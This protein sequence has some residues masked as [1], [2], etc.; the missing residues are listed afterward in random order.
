M[1]SYKDGKKRKRIQRHCGDIRP[2]PRDHV[3][4]LRVGSKCLIHSNIVKRFVEGSVVSIYRDEEG[5]WLK[6]RY[7]DTNEH[8][9]C[10]IQRFSKELLVFQRH[11]LWTQLIDTPEPDG[12]WKLLETNNL[13]LPPKL[14]NV[15][16]LNDNTLLVAARSFEDDHDE[17][18]GDD[19]AESEKTGIYKYDIIRNQWELFIKYPNGFFSENHNICCDGKEEMVYL[20]N[21]AG[22]GGI[23][24]VHV[25]NKRF[26]YMGKYNLEDSS[27]YGSISCVVESQYHIFW[28]K[29][30]NHHLCWKGD[31][32]K[33][34]I[35][36]R[37]EHIKKGMVSF[38]L[39]YNDREKYF[40]L[41]GGYMG[42]EEGRSDAVWRYRLSQNKWER[43][44]LTM[45][46]KMQSFGCVI[47]RNCKNVIIFG[48]SDSLGIS[49]KI[50]VLD[51]LEMQWRKSSVICPFKGIG[52]NNVVIAP[53]NNIVNID[54]VH[55]LQSMYRHITCPLSEIL[56]V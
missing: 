54:N 55:I 15:V 1:V 20:N 45:P 2:I 12:P 13:I 19:D 46:D 35:L 11:L 34:E 47:T 21:A 48:G 38:G 49:D 16:R 33:F 30:N 28:G 40:L 3:L 5:E 36:H 42:K 29:M 23:W 7:W 56:A 39:V 6:V 51:L 10:D 41:L 25:E 37:F 8:K 32:E 18:D 31:A 14:S 53:S 24:R 43:L 26:E 44:E 4:S 17:D 9:L 52:F 50:Y 27:S 22:G